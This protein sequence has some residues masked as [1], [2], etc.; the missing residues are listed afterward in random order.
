M[1]SHAT[2]L[3]ATVFPLLL[4]FLPACRT[5][6]VTPPPPPSSLPP[7]GA[8]AAPSLPIPASAGLSAALHILRWNPTISSFS[9]DTFLE[10]LDRLGRDGTALTSWSLHDWE[11][12]RPGDWAVFARVGGEDPDTDGIAGICRI[13][14][15]PYEAPSWRGD[16]STDH[17]AEIDIRFLNDPASTGLLSA[18]ELDTFFPSVDWHGGHSGV[19]V[20]PG[21]ADRM[22]L[23]IADRLASAGSA[24]FPASSF[25]TAADGWEFLPANLVAYLCPGLRAA[26]SSD[27]SAPLRLAPDW[28]TPF[29]PNDTCSSTFHAPSGD[30]TVPFMNR[31]AAAIRKTLSIP[32]WTAL[33]LPLAG[34]TFELLFLVPPRD[35]TPAEIEAGIPEALASERTATGRIRSV[36]LSLPKLAVS[37]TGPVLRSVRLELDEGSPSNLPPTTPLLPPESSSRPL[38]VLLNRPF[39][40]ALRD[41]Q[42]SSLLLLSRILSP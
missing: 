8:D 32:G 4:I 6:T 39:V 42:T 3:P 36:F 31:D 34:D 28:P 37:A 33:V 24:T 1:K 9:E 22:A 16:G 38:R 41:T 20:P 11:A 27:P 40:L 10:G 14:S 35:A 12:V 5:S 19:P 26:P 2:I 7:A 18:P 21:T 17:Y 15:P 30:V 23:V 29:D 13:A 25:A